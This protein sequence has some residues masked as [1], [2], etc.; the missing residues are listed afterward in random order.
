MGII[1]FRPQ[2]IEAQS[3]QIIDRLVGDMKLP[4]PQEEII[5]RVIH[6]TAD[7]DYVQN[8]IFHPQATTSGLRVIRAG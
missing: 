4:Q 6:A 5:K 1:P 7:T 3:L 2:Q 8:L